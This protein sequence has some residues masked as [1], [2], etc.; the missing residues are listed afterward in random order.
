MKA[1]EYMAQDIDLLRKRLHR[2]RGHVH[3]VGVGGVGMSGLARLL[4]AQGFTVSGGDCHANPLM[5]GLRRRGM[6]IAAGHSHLH[7]TNDVDMI[8]HSTAI[9][10]DHP[11]LRRARSNKIP[12]FHRGVVLAAFIRDIPTIAVSGTHGKTTTTAMIA[13]ILRHAGLN[14]SYCLGG[15]VQGLDGS[16]YWGGTWPAGGRSGRERRHPDLLSS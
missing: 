12:V 1:N 10:S 9:A 14:L 2:K 3:C 7:I 13:Q 11:E 8:V 4:Q 15:E 6:T 5:D 16:A